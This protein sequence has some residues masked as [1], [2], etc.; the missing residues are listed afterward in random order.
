[1]NCG[2]GSV[3]LR[4]EELASGGATPADEAAA[5]ALRLTLPAAASDVD[6]ARRA[7][8]ALV[9]GGGAS[10]A[11]EALRLL[12][13]DKAVAG[14]LD[15]T[16][17]TGDLAAEI[18]QVAAE[19]GEDAV[20]FRFATFARALSSPALLACTPAAAI[21]AVLRLLTLFAG[22]DG[23]ALWLVDPDGRPVCFAVVGAADPDA[24]G[25]AAQAFTGGVPARARASV[26]VPQRRLGAVAGALAARAADQPDRV[27]SFLETASGALES[28]LE[29][30][31]LLQ[32]SVEHEIAITAPLEKRLGRVAL[33]LHD[34]PLQDLAALGRDLAL[35]RSQIE[36]VVVTDDRAH[37]SGR[38]DDLAARL[39]GLDFALRQLVESVRGG[40]PRS[41]PIAQRLELEVET[42][43]EDGLDAWI[44]TAGDFSTLSDSQRITVLRVV[45]EAL[46]NVREH[47]GAS[48][49]GVRVAARDGGV[50]ATIEDDGGGFDPVRVGA[51]A[52]RRR[53]FGIAG[54]RERV[55][56]LG[57]D[58]RVVSEPGQGTRIVLVLHPWRPV[59]ME[60]A[61][62]AI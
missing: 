29:R 34:G 52:V 19:A 13:A 18:E 39:E 27:A 4:T 62:A 44:E 49:V 42:L 59:Q 40:C 10:A 47:S 41:E 16:R 48:T 12:A 35:A 53:R 31:L 56:L 38:F 2:L 24:P 55:R 28:V 45:H 43:R 14:V 33:D 7:V 23:A 1:M 58:L 25:A 32:Q 57:G 21:E 15:G 9:A 5:P 30:E 61:E 60:P 54:M 17:A 36:S 22:V 51:E 50:E 8:L 6:D 3:G 11:A 46:A 20:G 37:V 26:A